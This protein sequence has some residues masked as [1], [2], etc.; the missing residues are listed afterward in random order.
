[1]IHA[2]VCPILHYDRNASSW[3]YISFSCFLCTDFSKVMSYG[4]VRISSTLDVSGYT[5]SLIRYPLRWRPLCKASIPC[6]A[7]FNMKSTKLAKKSHDSTR[8]IRLRLGCQIPKQ[9]ISWPSRHEVTPS[10]RGLIRVTETRHESNHSKSKSIP[11]LISLRGANQ[12]V[13]APNHYRQ[14]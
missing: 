5:V 6:L 10:F 7:V 13:R 8:T 3:R 11:E 1:M 12:R 2:A 14:R 4:F 9:W